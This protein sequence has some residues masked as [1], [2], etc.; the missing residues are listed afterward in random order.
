M[1]IIL[2]GRNTLI[3]RSIFEENRPR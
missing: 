1:A 3:L 2:H